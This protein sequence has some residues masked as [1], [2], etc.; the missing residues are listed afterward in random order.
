M[1]LLMIILFIR[2]LRISLSKS[3]NGG[4][5]PTIV[6]TDIAGNVARDI[7]KFQDEVLNDNVDFRLDQL[8]AGL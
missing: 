2:H 4:T 6:I 7:H 8:G 5:P 1:F 3:F